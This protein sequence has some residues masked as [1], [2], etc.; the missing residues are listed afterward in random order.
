MGDFFYK[1]GVNA[2]KDIKNPGPGTK[3]ERK[4]EEVQAQELKP[5]E[6]VRKVQAQELNGIPNAT[7][8]KSWQESLSD[9]L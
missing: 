3:T 1:T 9:Y 7:K 5:K 2:E 4:Y 6:N 8:E